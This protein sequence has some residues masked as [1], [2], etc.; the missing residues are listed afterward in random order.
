MDR[1]QRLRGMNLRYLCVL[2][3]KRNGR[4]G[5]EVREALKD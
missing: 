5:V 3:H 4:A 2:K 1:I